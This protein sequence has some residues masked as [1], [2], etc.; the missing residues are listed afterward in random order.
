MSYVIVGLG[1]PDTEYEGTRHNF[2]RDLVR[3]IWQKEFFSDWKEDP[4]TKSLVAKGEIAGKKVTLVLPET[5]M[6]KSGLAVKHFVTSRKASER[7][8]VIYDELDIPLGSFK[9]SF[10]RGDGGHNGVKSIISSLKTKDFVRIR[11]GISKETPGGKLKKI[12][13]EK[14]ILDFLMNT[15]TPAEKKN[16]NAVRKKIQAAVETIISEGRVKAMNIHN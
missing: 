13:G 1:N 8:I 2:G 5:Y 16:F 14:K 3:S 10:G 4:K 11:A 7:L 12:R 15:F 9:I 6:N